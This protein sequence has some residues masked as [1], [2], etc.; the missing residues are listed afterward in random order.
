V[1]VIDWK[2]SS[3]KGPIMCWWGR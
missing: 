1:E 3:P 2:E